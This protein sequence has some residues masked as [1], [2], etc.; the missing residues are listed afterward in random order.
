MRY[1]HLCN[2]LTNNLLARAILLGTMSGM[3]SMSA[4]AL[5]AQR[6]SNHPK[7]FKGTFFSLLTNK[8]VATLAALMSLGEIVADKLPIIPTRI[9][10]LPL[11]GRAQLGAFSGA[12]AYTEARQSPLV[13]AAIGALSA[14]ASTHLF[15]RLRKG[16]TDALHIPD[17]PVAL[18]EDASV[19]GLGRTVLSLYK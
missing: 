14:V 12:A 18:A 4:P 2:T 10:P 13:G 19:V 7:G 6:A 1:K 8:N 15:Y 17:L 11:L 3:R 5:M 16:I 9:K